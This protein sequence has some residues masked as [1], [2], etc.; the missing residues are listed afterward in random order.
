MLCLDIMT[1]LSLIFLKLM[2]ILYVVKPMLPVGGY[3]VIENFFAFHVIILP[4]AV[5]YIVRSFI[6]RS[7]K[8]ANGR[9]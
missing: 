9:W 8:S 5:A 3:P 6:H 1:F 4:F 7:T 2:S